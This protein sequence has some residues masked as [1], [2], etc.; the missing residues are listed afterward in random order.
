VVRH[1]AVEPDERQHDEGDER[2]AGEQV[3]ERVRG[4]VLGELVAVDAVGEVVLRR[5]GRAGRHRR[6]A[7]EPNGGDHQQD[8][9]RSGQ[10]VDPA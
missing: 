5:V 9:H 10:P 6:L 8:Q 3:D 4:E 1:D 2:R 7:G